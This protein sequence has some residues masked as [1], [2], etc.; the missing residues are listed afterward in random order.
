MK[1][2]QDQKSKGKNIIKKILNEAAKET[3]DKLKKY[4]EELRK[5]K[6]ET[7]DSASK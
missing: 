2:P 7:I 1:I 5:I 6:K 3:N 4:L